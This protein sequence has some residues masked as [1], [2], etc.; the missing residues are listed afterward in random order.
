MSNRRKAGVGIS[1]PAAA[2][3]RDLV[4]EALVDAAATAKL[5]GGLDYPLYLVLE[6]AL[7]AREAGRVGELAVWL[8]THWDTSPDDHPAVA[9]NVRG[10]VEAVLAEDEREGRF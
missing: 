6:H 9:A 10:R 1:R 3:P 5:M 7:K 8:E 2:E 4:F